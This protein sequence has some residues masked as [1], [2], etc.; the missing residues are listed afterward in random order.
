MA[1]GHGHRSAT[2]TH[3]GLHSGLRPRA[4]TSNKRMEAKETNIETCTNKQL[5]KK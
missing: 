1:E 5:Q 3:G 4:P 2:G